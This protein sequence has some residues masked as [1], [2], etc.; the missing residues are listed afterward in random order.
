MNLFRHLF[1]LVTFNLLGMKMATMSNSA[2][3]KSFF[4]GYG[5]IDTFGKVSES[6]VE[7]KNVNKSCVCVQN[8]F[9][10]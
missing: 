3:F 10:F 6:C 5:H 9:K 8:V 4:V 7:F 1:E 2:K